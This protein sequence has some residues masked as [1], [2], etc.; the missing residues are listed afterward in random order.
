[1]LPNLARPDP[2]LDHPRETRL[3]S[4]TLF[5]VLAGSQAH[6]TAR[7]DSDTDYRSV[8]YVPTRELLGLP[9]RDRPRFSDAVTGHAG[10]DGWEVEQALELA[11]RGHPSALEL[12]HNPVEHMT[13]NCSE[14]YLGFRRLLAA[15]PPAKAAVDA[16]LGYAKNCLTK[17]ISERRPEQ[18]AKLKATYLRTLYAVREWVET[19]TYPAKVPLHGWG[20]LVRNALLSYE[21]G[22]TVTPGTVVDLGR[23]VEA[24]IGRLLPDSPVREPRASVAEASGWLLVFRR[25]HWDA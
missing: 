1:M 9:S 15:L 12:A 24:E 19:G 23:V 2:H 4:T 3:T 20:S 22:G 6:G 25:E 13:S 11:L 7:E 10:G 21:E 8:Y 17:L 14:D 5:R 16:H 18:E